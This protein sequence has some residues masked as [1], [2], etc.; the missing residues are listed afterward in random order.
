MQ[1][2][3]VRAFLRS[4][5][6]DAAVV[7]RERTASKPEA[8]GVEAIGLTHKTIHDARQVR[9]VEDAPEQLC[10]CQRCDFRG[11]MGTSD[12]FGS[13]PRCWCLVERVDR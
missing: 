4:C 3:Y 1:G 11:F 10:R 13:L 5:V 8:V 6:G 9:D 12:N 2:E 7:E